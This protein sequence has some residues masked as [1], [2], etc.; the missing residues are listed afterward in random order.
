MTTITRNIAQRSIGFVASRLATVAW[1]VAAAVNLAW[2][3]L[4]A[5]G[6]AKLL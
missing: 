2:I 6:L 5:Y 4:L 3:G 1:V